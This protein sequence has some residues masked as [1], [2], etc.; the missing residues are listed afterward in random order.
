MSAPFAHR[1]CIWEATARKPGNVHRYADFADLTYLDFA[2]SAGAILPAL[3]DAPNRPLGETVLTAIRA[4]R[5]VVST[6]TNLGIVLLLA[7]LASVP[8]GT[9]LRTGVSAVLA[10]TTVADAA[11]VYEAIRLASPGG[12]GRAD[13]ED[14]ADAPTMPL[15]AVMTL[16]A[17]RDGVARQYAAGF[18]DV[19][20]TGVPVLARAFART[21]TLEQAIIGCHLAL[22]AKSGDTLI[23]RKRGPAESELARQLAAG[24]LTGQMSVAAFDEW[25]RGAGGRNPGTTADL[26]TA[27]LYA[28]QRLGE[29]PA[30]AVAW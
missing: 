25:L 21:G 6:N 5:A 12:L 24:V 11:A 8:E 29:L 30:G 9:D 16:A 28:A 20:D 23:A 14:V 19:F 18:A 26:V 4:T 10:R 17:E 13:A 3:A 27:A 2:L 15:T 1:A 7:P 22:L